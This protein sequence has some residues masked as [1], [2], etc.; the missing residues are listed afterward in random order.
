VEFQLE[1]AIPVLERTPGVLT[2]LLDDVPEE[3]TTVTEG[4][5]T[6]SPRQV[7]AHL[8]HGERTDWIPRAR[9]I[10]KQD[11][12]RRFTP[13]DRFADLNPDRSLRDLLKEFDQLRSGNVATL[14]G[15]NLKEKDLDLIGEHPEFGDVT[16]R[17]L[18]ATWVV[19]DLSHIAQ[20]TRTM[21]RAYTV[22]VGPWTK[23]FRVLQRDQS[24]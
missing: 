10:I 12:Y 2:T 7:V 16:M 6:W 8:L 21:A 13:F 11:S 5:D 3:W 22:A 1:Q 20:I 18:L 9:I 4:P 19:H 24:Q 15:W 23:Y 14:R 17:Q